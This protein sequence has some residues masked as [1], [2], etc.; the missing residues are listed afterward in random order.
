M[1][2]P[3]SKISKRYNDER[4]KITEGQF[5]FLPRLDPRGSARGAHFENDLGYRHEN[6]RNRRRHRKYRAQVGK[7]LRFIKR[8]RDDK[9]Y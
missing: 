5:S 4:K 9:Q 3:K 7:V 1:P 2:K 6:R 8:R